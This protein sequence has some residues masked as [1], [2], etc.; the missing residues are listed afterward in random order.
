MGASAVRRAWRVAGGMR[1]RED[2]VAAA[3]R[4]QEGTH[5]ISQQQGMGGQ[6]RPSRESTEQRGFTEQEGEGRQGKA[7][8]MN[9]PSDG[10]ECLSLQERSFLN[11]GQDEHGR[12]RWELEHRRRGVTCESGSLGLLT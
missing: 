6:A 11:W 9:F 7:E 12:T 3:L 8:A 2:S 4:G 1:G 5:S 10:H